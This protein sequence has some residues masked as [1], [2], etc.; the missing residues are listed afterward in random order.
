MCT[1]DVLDGFNHPL[2]SLTV[3]GHAQTLLVYDVPSQDAFV[4]VSESREG[5]SHKIAC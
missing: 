3:L 5:F 2:Q 4:A 1:S